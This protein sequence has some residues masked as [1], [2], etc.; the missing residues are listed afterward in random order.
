VTGLVLYDMARRQ[1]MTLRDLYNLTAAAR[2]HWVICGT[3]TRIADTL[4]MHDPRHPL[5]A[6]FRRLLLETARVHLCPRT[7]RLI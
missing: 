7:R 5:T 1:N 4:E 6:E 3:P 2:G